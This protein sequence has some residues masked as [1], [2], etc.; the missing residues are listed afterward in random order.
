MFNVHV[1]IPLMAI[2]WKID[3]TYLQ[4]PFSIISII[5]PL[6]P[7]AWWFFITILHHVWSLDPVFFAMFDASNPHLMRGSKPASGSCSKPG[8]PSSCVSRSGSDPSKTLPDTDLEVRY[9]IYIKY[10]NIKAF[11]WWFIRVKRLLVD[12]VGLRLAHDW[13]NILVEWMAK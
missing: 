8:L 5:H 6:D 13:G 3:P 9:K 4:T 10:I 7:Q 1:V 2:Y 11:F 12:S